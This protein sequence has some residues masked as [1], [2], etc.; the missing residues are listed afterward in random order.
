MAD[1]SERPIGC[2]RFG[3]AKTLQFSC[4]CNPDNSIDPM[5]KALVQSSEFVT[6][7]NWWNPKAQMFGSCQDCWNKKSALIWKPNIICLPQT[8]VCLSWTISFIA[9]YIQD[10]YIRFSLSKGAVHVVTTPDEPQIV[11]PRFSQPGLPMM[12]GHYKILGNKVCWF[13]FHCTSM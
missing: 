6:F 4:L 3:V 10:N 12:Q 13:F 8:G 2:R 5:Q 9:L 1:K 7:P 11:V